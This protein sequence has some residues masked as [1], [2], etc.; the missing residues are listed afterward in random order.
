MN[1]NGYIY[2]ATNFL[3]TG[4]T[5]PR[6]DKYTEGNKHSRHYEKGI[7]E[8]YRKVRTA[9][10]RYVFFA[11]TH[12]PTKKRWLASL[13]YPILPY[14]KQKNKNYKLGEFQTVSLI[15]V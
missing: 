13:K 15:K 11:T 3:F 2:Q 12:K 7:E 6:T 5:K 4:T 8:K 9:K 10:N 1:H 14:P